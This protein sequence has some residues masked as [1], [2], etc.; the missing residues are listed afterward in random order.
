MKLLRMGFD[1]D[2]SVT[3]GIPVIELEKKVKETGAGL[4]IIGSHGLSWTEAVLGSTA[5]ELLHNMKY[6]VLLVVLRRQADEEV[7]L[8]QKNI[9]QYE[10]ILKQLERKEP[11]WEHFIVSMPSLANCIS[12]YAMISNK[13]EKLPP[14]FFKGGGTGVGRNMLIKVNIELRLGFHL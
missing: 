13:T 9:Y 3:Y 12:A 10:M 8:P 2:S 11:V 14:P 7:P 4:I 5:S 1:V 6:P